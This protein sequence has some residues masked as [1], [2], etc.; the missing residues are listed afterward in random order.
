VTNNIIGEVE[1][2]TID[3]LRIINGKL[4]FTF[5]FLIVLGRMSYLN[6]FEH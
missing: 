3:H 1:A 5:G 6:V 4:I 2:T